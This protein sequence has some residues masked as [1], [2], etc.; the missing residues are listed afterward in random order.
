MIKD[1]GLP[2][3]VSDVAKVGD[4]IFYSI[5]DKN[6]AELAQVPEVEASIV[7]LNQYNGAIVASLIG[8]YDF[9]KSKFD[10]TTQST[11]QTGSNFK[12]FLYSAAV[13]KS[14]NINSILG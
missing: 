11:R 5:N 10:R 4:L 12:P 2:P 9:A 13:A 1:R 3:K 6:E 14:I 7:A 8:S